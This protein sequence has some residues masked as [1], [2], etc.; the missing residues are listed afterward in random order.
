MTNGEMS[1]SDEYDVPTLNMLSGVF[2]EACERAQFL[3]H[4][5]GADP[6][7][8]RAELAR[9]IMAAA[10]IGERDP[11]RLKLI[12]LKDLDAGFTQST[13]TRQ[14]VARVDENT[15]PK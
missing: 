9:R 3:L 12:A 1:T 6:S 2:Y 10:K 13:N 15:A 7:A 8:I 5:S 4:A 14:S 11:I